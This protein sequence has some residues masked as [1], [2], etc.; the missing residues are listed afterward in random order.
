M[1]SSRLRSGRYCTTWS[2][3]GS[4]AK[5]PTPKQWADIVRGIELGQHPDMAALA[6][7]VSAE[8]LNVWIRQDPEFAHAV[9]V[10]DAKANAECH[11]L[12]AEGVA[13]GLKTTAVQWHM[14][15][16]WPHLYDPKVSKALER[17]FR[18]V[19]AV[20]EAFDE[21][22]GAEVVDRIVAA[23]AGGRGRSASAS[24]AGVKVH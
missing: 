24:A 4:L 11:R 21:E 3:G 5:G 17:E 1:R 20:L 8:M 14:E 9:H 22:L 23:V 6:A 19:V 7:G 16:R 15:R 13:E 18:R 12:L 2:G 10:A